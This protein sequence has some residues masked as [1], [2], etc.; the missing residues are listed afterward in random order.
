MSSGY[1]SE[2]RGNIRALAA[3]TLG[4]SVG[5]ALNAYTTAVFAPALIKE[6]GWTRSQFAL[7]GVAALPAVMF[8]PF[9]GA[10]ADRFGVRRVAAL[11]VLLLPM[12]SVAFSMMSGSFGYYLFLMFL[13]IGVGMATSVV[14][15]TRIVA[16]RFRRARGLALTIITCGPALLGALAAPALTFA[17][18]A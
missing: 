13:Q 11:G 10:M 9:I 5:L 3:A 4:V 17:I 14:V 15:Y 1:L 16:E 18:E 6:F 2:F 12:A 8:A 7:V